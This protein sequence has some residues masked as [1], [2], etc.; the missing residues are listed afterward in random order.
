MKFGYRNIVAGCAILFL[1]AVGG[2]ALGLTLDHFLDKGFYAIPLNRLLIKAGHTHGMP[3]ALYN[4]IIGSL[5]D[6]LALD[7]AW[8]KRCSSAALLAFLMPVGLILRGLDNGAP[9]FAVVVFFGALFF[10]TSAGIVIK[11]A[12]AERGKQ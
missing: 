7:D 9:T 11:G 1:G 10:L 5:V 2:F 8:K 3:F 6:R 12:L 4:I